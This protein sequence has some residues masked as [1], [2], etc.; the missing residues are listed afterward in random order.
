MPQHG[1][2]GDIVS[3]TSASPQ[4]MGFTAWTLQM[5]R[6][7]CRRRA[8]N[9]LRS[10]GDPVAGRSPVF[11]QA[12]PAT[13]RDLPLSRIPHIQGIRS[14]LRGEM[15]SDHTVT[16]RHSKHMVDFGASTGDSE[17][18]HHAGEV[19]MLYVVSACLAGVSCRF[20]GGHTPREQVIELVRQGLALP[21]CPE[22]LGGLPTP[23]PPCELRGGHVV[24][25]DGEDVTDAFE[26][27]VVEGVRLAVMAGCT[28]AILKARSPSCGC[29]HV[30]DGTF[31]GR[32]VPGDG[33]FA[34]ALRAAG[35]SV[36]P[37]DSL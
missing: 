10:T 29:G 37:D 17:R 24:T 1:T 13:P 28:E 5:A 23:R 34:K 18:T 4:G 19:T 9:R 3:A 25:I 7:L 21:V 15:T 12:H 2:R 27:G 30:Y 20:D 6:N 35:I 16:M 8:M 14:I 11:T 33:V 31:S 32:L 36:R 22:Q 26:R